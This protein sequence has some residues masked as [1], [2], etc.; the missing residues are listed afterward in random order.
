MGAPMDTPQLISART[1]YRILSA[2]LLVGSLAVWPHL[3]V[4]QS[5]PPDG[6]GGP[7]QVG[8]RWVYDTKNEV[9][10]YPDESFTEM[11][12][13]VAPNEI[14]MNLTFREPVHRLPR[15]VI[16]TY[17]HDW[18]GIDNLVWKFKP[19][20]GLGIR[21][22]LSA[23]KTW[24]A[25]FDA[26]NLDT[27]VNYRGTSLSKVV[28]QETITTSAGTFDTFKIEQQAR[29]F[30][31]AD[32]AK[33]WESQVVGWFAPQINHWV[34]RTILTKFDKRTRSNTSEELA[35]FS[36]NL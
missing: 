36:R 10:G 11:V 32:P 18:N 24:R 33:M 12:T 3:L 1:G 17:D 14:I 26:K 22:P 21:L 6:T 8:D 30:R 34:R 16:V 13:K 4:A 29:Y 20:N 35:D 27:G 7:A 23:G 5:S 15:A 9:T 31:A 25:E 19:N 2:A 28:A